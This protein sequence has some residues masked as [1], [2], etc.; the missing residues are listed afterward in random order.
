MI[1]YIDDTGKKGAERNGGGCCGCYFAW[2]V[3]SASLQWNV[4]QPMA[5]DFRNQQKPPRQHIRR[6]H[7][8]DRQTPNQTQTVK[9]A[10]TRWLWLI[11]QPHWR[12]S[13]LMR[14]ERDFQFPFSI[15]SEKGI[16]RT[17]G[18]LS[19]AHQGWLLTRILPAPPPIWPVEEPSLTM[20]RTMVDV[21]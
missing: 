4:G 5:F 9:K 18:I 13:F 19:P 12:G 20:A 16:V 21:N 15:C 1:A 2:L 8:V 11:P 3:S 14:E 10:S 7:S 6:D 17:I